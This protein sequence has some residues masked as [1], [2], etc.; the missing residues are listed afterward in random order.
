MPTYVLTER[1]DGCRDRSLAACAYIC[2]HDLMR[3]DAD[4]A[5]TGHATQ[6]YN[7]E[8]ARC[9]ECYACIKACPQDAIG[10]RPAADVAPLGGSVHPGRDDT[11]IAWDIGFRDGRSERFEYPVRTTPVGSIDPYGGKPA[12]DIRRIADNGF[13]V[14]LGGYRSGDPDELVAK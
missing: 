3:I 13:F 10:S 6:A 1:C 7:R 2:P 4:G 5:E 14:G 12:A 8:P 9:W 11:V